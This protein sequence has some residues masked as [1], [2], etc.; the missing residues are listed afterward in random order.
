MRGPRSIAFVAV[1]GVL[2]AIAGCAQETFPGSA[3]S[4]NPDAGANDAT[5]PGPAIPFVCRQAQAQPLPQRLVAMSANASSSGNLVLMSDVFQ[6]FIEACGQCHGPSVDPPGQGGFQIIRE[7]DFRQGMTKDVLA[8]VTGA[9]CPKAENPSDPLDPMPPC[10]DTGNT[11][12]FAGRSEADPVKQFGD[13]TAA[14][15]AAGSPDS[16]TPPGMS[17]PDSGTADG[18]TPSSFTLNPRDGNAMTN[19]GSC[20]PNQ[21]L[22]D[23]SRVVALDAKFAAMQ[24]K[25]NGSAADQI[26]LP[27]DLDETDLF[28]LDTAQ[29]A[30]T[31]VVAYAPGYPLWSD[32]AGKLRYVRVPKG[33]SIHFDKTTQQFEI[34][35]NTRFYK[36]FMRQIIDTDGSYRYKKIETRLIVSRPDMNNSDGTAAAQTA[37]FGTYRWNEDESDAKLVETLLRDQRPFGDTLLAYHINEPLAADLIKGQPLNLAETLLENGASRN[38][39]I[40]GAPRCMQCHM[41]S[42]SQSFILGF[43]PLQI[44]RRPEGA[45]GTIEATG[46][47]ELNQLQRLIDAGVITG[48]DAP[49]DI[50]PL[51]QSQGTRKPRNAHELLAQGYVLGNCSHCHNPRGFPTVQNPQLQGVLDFL[52]STN[53]GLFQFPLDRFSP[54]I[55]R[56]L[57]GTTLIPYVTPSLVD[58]PR[59]DPLTGNQAGDPFVSTSGPSSVNWVD[60][61]PWRSIIYRN[62]DSVF[63]YTDDEALFPHMPMNTPGYDPRAKEILGDWMLSIPAVRKHPEIPEYSYQIDEVASNNIGGAPDT[64]PQPYVEVTPDQSGYAAALSA[65][66]ARLAIFH[67]GFNPALPAAQTLYSRYADR[68]LTSDI[69]DPAVTADPICHPTPQPN[70]TFYLNPLAEHPDWVNTDLTDL[71]EWSPRRANWVDVLISHNIPTPSGGCTSLAGQQTAYDDQVKAVSLLQTAKLSDVEAF[72]TT[73][74][75]FGLWQPQAGCNYAGVPKV[76]DLGNPGKPPRPHWVDVLEPQPAASAPVYMEA[77]GAAVF[78]MICI[79]CH[80]PKAD[81]NGRLAQNLATMTGGNALVANFRDGLFGPVGASEPASHRAAFYSVPAIQAALNNP[82]F[83]DPNWTD[84][85]LSDDDRTARYMAWMGLGGTAVHIPVEILQIVAITKVLDKQRTL[86]AT[87]LSANMLSEAKALCLSL[88]GPAFKDQG[89]VM[90]PA[91]LGGQGYL[92]GLGLALNSTLIA[93]NGDA[94]LW[95]RLC[96]IANPPPIQVLK[97]ETGGLALASVPTPW[98]SD[99]NIIPGKMVAASI[100]PP[101]T[102]VGNERGG[103]D[104]SLCTDVSCTTPN[105]W[106]WCID[107]SSATSQQLSWMGQN[108]LPACPAAVVAATNCTGDV[109]ACAT[110]ANDDANRW[111]V[112]GAINAGMSVFTYVRSIENSSPP[113]DY[114]QCPQ[115]N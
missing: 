8:H 114:N 36:T 29:L 48:V 13:L 111:A 42:P 12:S 38:Y 113:A 66:S 30:A 103:V 24:A 46:P 67:T 70:P 40:P 43:T 11:P 5:T 109:V 2:F 104:S 39:A 15:L 88:L 95:L 84:P 89:A 9:V 27:E 22:R 19:L 41:G 34:P 75:P 69:I 60:Y 14:W 6:D 57:S 52:P 73:A 61:A 110:Q 100:Y 56:G 58:L 62:V 53:G 31:G 64:E 50:L 26:G 91:S 18:G 93:S 25:P 23:D 68:G 105:L 72:A 94:E 20:V 45:G 87:S 80:G 55:G 112:R 51:E 28:T 81:A 4:S 65:V 71:P 101:S 99:G 115:T 59:R 35:P 7:T 98:T 86:V 90:L 1:I 37:L 82:S 107:A 17:A 10:I 85:S 54:R 96:S 32:D 16:F 33:Q 77:P 76:S 49:S 74:R 97:L 102:P 3:F 79:N 21:L 44:N 92:G 63:A 106:P 78:K 83:Q 108:G 47:D